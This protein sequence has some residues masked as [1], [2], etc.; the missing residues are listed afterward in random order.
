MKRTRDMFRPEFRVHTIVASDLFS[1]YALNSEDL[2]NSENWDH[3]KSQNG[4]ND[5]FVDWQ[6]GH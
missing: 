4:S 5:S 6:K 3:D 2:Y 1:V